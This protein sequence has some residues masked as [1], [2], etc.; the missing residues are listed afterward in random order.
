MRD[1]SAQ[2]SRN[3]HKALES[4][5]LARRVPA[6]GGN[7][8][9]FCNTAC[10]LPY[11]SINTY[12]KVVSIASRKDR[13]ERFKPYSARY[14]T[15]GGRRF[16]WI[17]VGFSFAVLP[18]TIPPGALHAVSTFRYRDTPKPP[19]YPVARKSEARRRGKGAH[20]EV[21]QRKA[22]TLGNGAHGAKEQRP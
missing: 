19:R 21:D 11:N 18:W 16:N 8:R 14:R 3:G 13:P 7:N 1:Y 6:H 5:R 4:M 15:L 10:K 22:R 12:R 9:K 17:K 2:V 20:F